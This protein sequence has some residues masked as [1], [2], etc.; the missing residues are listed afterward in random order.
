MF[1]LVEFESGASF[2]RV[3]SRISGRIHTSTAMY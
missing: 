2:Q 1:I 3:R